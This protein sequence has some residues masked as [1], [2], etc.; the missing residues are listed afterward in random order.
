M[1]A[2]RLLALTASAA[3]AVSAVGLAMTLSVVVAP[4]LGWGVATFVTGVIAFGL[5]RRELD[6]HAL[7]RDRQREQ[8]ISTAPWTAA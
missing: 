1:T 8:P 7:E 2:E 3:F 4:W 6:R 5:V